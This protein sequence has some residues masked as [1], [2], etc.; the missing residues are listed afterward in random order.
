MSLLGSCQPVYLKAFSW[1]ISNTLVL[2]EISKL[3]LNF[4]C[5]QTILDPSPRSPSSYLFL[6]VQITQKIPSGSWNRSWRRQEVPTCCTIGAHSTDGEEDVSVSISISMKHLQWGPA[7]Y[8]GEAGI[9]IQCPMEKEYSCM[10]GPPDIPQHLGSSSPQAWMGL[11]SG[12]W[13]SKR[14]LRVLVY[15][16]LLSVS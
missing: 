10:T 16:G 1:S 2:E 6:P 14:T 5:P 11:K 9:P 12:P 15:G 4:Q 8:L 3:L 13:S 7:M